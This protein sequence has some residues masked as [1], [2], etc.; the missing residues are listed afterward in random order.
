MARL[1]RERPVF[2]NR[3]TPAECAFH[4]QLTAGYGEAFGKARIV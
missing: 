3:V 2:V 4:L 1:I